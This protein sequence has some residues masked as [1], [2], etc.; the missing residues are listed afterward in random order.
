VLERAEHSVHDVAYV[1][2]GSLAGAIASND[3]EVIE[4]FR[5]LSPGGRLI[6][7]LAK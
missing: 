7:T 4:D 2:L 3:D 1:I 5:V 6:T